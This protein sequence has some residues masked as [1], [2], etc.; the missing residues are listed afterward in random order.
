MAIPQAS[1]IECPERGRTLAEAD[2]FCENIEP[3]EGKDYGWVWDYAKDTF[4][5]SRADYRDLETKA[6]EIIKYLGGG[7]GLFTLGVLASVNHNNRWVVLCVIPSYLAALTSI[8]FA[9]RVRL[10]MRVLFP[11]TVEGAYRYADHYGGPSMSRA[12]FLG[13]WHR[14]CVGIDLAVSE[15]ARLVRRA[16]WAFFAAIAGLAIP[17]VGAFLLA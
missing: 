4:A 17:L 7:T 1:A 10:P 12:T 3:D 11:P 13:Q 9:V 6:S 14:A 2:A 8:F 16:T 15:K 5:W